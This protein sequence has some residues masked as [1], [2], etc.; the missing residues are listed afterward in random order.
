MGPE[1]LGRSSG[2]APCS[3]DAVAG[4][5]LLCVY[6]CHIPIVQCDYCVGGDVVPES[7]W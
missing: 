5:I 2:S 6:I 7:N 4:P 3:N 1:G